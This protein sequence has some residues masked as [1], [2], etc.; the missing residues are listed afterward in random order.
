M[1]PQLQ[2]PPGF[3]ELSADEQV[4]YVQSLW[5]RIAARESEISVPDW[6]REEIERR[7]RDFEANPT[8]GR[9]WPEV[10]A[11]LRAKRDS[12]K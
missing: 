2:P 4:E 12:Q 3:D 10:L 1:K 11:E 6:H 8:A 7:L 5:D 9:P